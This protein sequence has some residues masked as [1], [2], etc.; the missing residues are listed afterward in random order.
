MLF[1]LTYV[2]RPSI[3]YFDVFL[4]KLVLLYNTYEICYNVFK[5]EIS[6]NRVKIEECYFLLN[7][8]RK[9]VISILEEGIEMN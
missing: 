5:I 3:I 6:K 8:K 2:F 7:K 9:I 4:L 1:D